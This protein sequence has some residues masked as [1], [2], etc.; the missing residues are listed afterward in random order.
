MSYINI[1]KFVL[2]NLLWVRWIRGCELCSNNYKKCKD[3]RALLFWCMHWHYLIYETISWHM[4]TFIHTIFLTNLLDKILLYT[5]VLLTNKILLYSPTL[6]PLQN[7]PT[8]SRLQSRNFTNR[9]LLSLTRF[10]L[11]KDG[12]KEPLRKEKLV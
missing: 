4:S 8:L 1:A 2:I 9:N 12:K 5:P 3:G 10:E 11:D 7:I 6:S